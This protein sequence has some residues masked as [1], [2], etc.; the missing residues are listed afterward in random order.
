MQGFGLSRKKFRICLGVVRNPFL[1][2]L[3][4]LL[5]RQERIRAGAL[6]WSFQQSSKKGGLRFS[7]LDSQ[8]SDIYY[9]C[10]R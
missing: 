7:E 4:G 1:T 3:P 9:R 2:T 6:K 5:H 8:Y 10:A